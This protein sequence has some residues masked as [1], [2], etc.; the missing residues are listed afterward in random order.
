MTTQAEFDAIEASLSTFEARV[1]AR[2]EA[3]RIHRAKGLKKLK[4]LGLSE[5]EVQALVG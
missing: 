2:E 5:E 3:M 1:Q 4:D